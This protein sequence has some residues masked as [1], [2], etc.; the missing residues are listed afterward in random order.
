[1]DGSVLLVEMGTECFMFI[2][3]DIFMV[4]R[5]G[6]MKILILCA[7]A[8]FVTERATVNKNEFRH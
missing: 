2:I 4:A 1:M 8:F 3:G 5:Y 6:S 7:C